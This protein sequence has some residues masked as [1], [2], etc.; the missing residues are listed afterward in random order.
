MVCWVGE[1]PEDTDSVR[2]VVPKEPGLVRVDWLELPLIPHE[3]L[4]G[5]GRINVRDT[6]VMVG[7]LEWEVRKRSR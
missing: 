5:F 3:F 6:G 1:E 4:R 2:W 7:G